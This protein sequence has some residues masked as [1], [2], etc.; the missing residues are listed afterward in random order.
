MRDGATNAV[1]DTYFAKVEQR[2]MPAARI[3]GYPIG[4]TVGKEQ[5]LTRLPVEAKIENGEFRY[6]PAAL[7][8]AYGKPI[9]GWTA[10]TSG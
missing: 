10:P 2:P 7:E 3:V 4:P 8:K 6:D 5:V 1:K 9:P